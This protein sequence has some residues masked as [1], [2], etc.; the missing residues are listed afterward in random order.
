MSLQIIILR[1]Q[2]AISS[3]F[4]IEEDKYRKIPSGV[5]QDKKCL[6]SEW[7]CE[8]VSKCIPVNKPCNEKCHYNPSYPMNLDNYTQLNIPA[9]CK[10]KKECIRQIDICNLHSSDHHE[11]CL[12][13]KDVCTNKQFKSRKC[14]N[15]NRSV[16]CGGDWLGQCIPRSY[17]MDGVYDCLD[18]SDE[19]LEVELLTSDSFDFLQYNLSECTTADGN[20]GLLC[21]IK[22]WEETKCIP[23]SEWCK[24]SAAGSI[25]KSSD[26]NFTCAA[27][28]DPVLCSNII[29]WNSIKRILRTGGRYRGGNNSLLIS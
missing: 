8:D 17:W 26:S 28:N 6:K 10:D 20:Q 13:A 3:V 4:I 18:R 14:P 1:L 29:F 15:P 24:P 9:Y 21:E 5:D 12:I 22:L 25:T 2:S 23:F 7:W 27:I 19:L 11:G 16:Q